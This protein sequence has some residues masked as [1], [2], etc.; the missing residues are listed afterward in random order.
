MKAFI[1]V[2]VDSKGPEHSWVLS[3]TSVYFENIHKDGHV[4]LL[5][6]Q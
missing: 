2:S 6:V 3:V 5:L 1:R 4:H